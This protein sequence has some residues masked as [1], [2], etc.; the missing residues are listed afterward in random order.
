GVVS[1]TSFR[2][3]VWRCSVLT[4]PQVT[5]WIAPTGSPSRRLTCPTTCSRSSTTT[6]STSAA[7]TAIP[8]QRTA[9]RGSCAL[10][11]SCGPPYVRARVWHRPAGC[12]ATSEE[13]EGLPLG[14]GR[15]R[16]G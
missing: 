16:H 15:E 1:S 12:A 7:P 3:E 11:G 10:T 4:R 14:R 13:V 9:D 6:S 5:F 8:R 2:Q